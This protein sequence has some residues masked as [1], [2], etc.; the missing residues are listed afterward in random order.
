MHPPTHAYIRVRMHTHTQKVLV[1]MRFII[2]ITKFPVTK[3]TN[4]QAVTFYMNIS[5]AVGQEQASCILF[6]HTRCYR[7]V[8]GL[9]QK[10]NSGLTYSI[11][12]AMSFKIVSLGT[13]TVIP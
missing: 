1:S 10:R 12:S 6:P 13:Y 8:P 11:L 2:V 3:A 5:Y 4:C 7:K 9:G